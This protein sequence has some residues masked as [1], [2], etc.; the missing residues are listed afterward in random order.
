LNLRHGAPAWTFIKYMQHGHADLHFKDMQA[1]ISS[2]SS[3]FYF[4]LAVSS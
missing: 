2:L 4:A 1:I 3:P